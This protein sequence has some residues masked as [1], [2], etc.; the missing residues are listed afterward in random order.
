METEQPDIFRTVAQLGVASDVGVDS[1]VQV[2]AKE[3]C[4]KRYLLEHLGRGCLRRKVHPPQE[5]LEAGVGAEED[6]A[7]PM[8]ILHDTQTTFNR[9]V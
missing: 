2:G 7:I 4:S 1:S 8:K 5:V 9:G 6:R 3:A